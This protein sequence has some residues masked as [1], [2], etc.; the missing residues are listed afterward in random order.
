MGHPVV[1]LD[2]IHWYLHV[3][4]YALFAFSTTQLS[5]TYHP[6]FADVVSQVKS[7]EIFFK[8][9]DHP[10]PW[11]PLLL[12]LLPHATLVVMATTLVVDMDEEAITLNV[13]TPSIA[14]F[15]LRKDAM[16]PFDVNA[17]PAPPTLPMLPI[18]WKL[19]PPVC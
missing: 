12:P 11:D 9:L 13:T 16:P 8:S 10:P 4:S 14:K 3:I 5:I 1:D 19:S 7:Y 2:K 6:S 17:T 18:W 15:I